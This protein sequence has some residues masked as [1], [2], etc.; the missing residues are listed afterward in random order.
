MTKLRIRIDEGFMTGLLG[1]TYQEDAFDAVKDALTVYSWAVQ[2]IA[3]GRDIFCAEAD[4][5]GARKITHFFNRY[6]L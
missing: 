4:G 3:D 5:R 6:N 2:E 1:K